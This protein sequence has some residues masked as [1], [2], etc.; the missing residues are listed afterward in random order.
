MRGWSTPINNPFL[1]PL[2][3]GEGAVSPEVGVLIPDDGEK[4]WVGRADTLSEVENFPSREDVSF[5]SSHVHLTSPFLCST[6]SLSYLPFLFMHLY[7][8]IEIL[9]FAAEK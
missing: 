7:V 6:A 2:G 9:L 3:A 4:W 1:E 5:A 8:D